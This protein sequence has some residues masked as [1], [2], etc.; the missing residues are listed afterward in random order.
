M[1]EYMNQY[2][3][4]KHFYSTHTPLIME[5]PRNEWAGD[6]YAWDRWIGMT[7][8]E[9]WL[10]GDIRDA[11]AV[12]YPQY[13]VG[14]FFVD[15]ANPRAKVAIECDGK[16]YHR[17]VEK[18]LARQREIEAMGWRVYRISGKQCMTDFN[19]ETLE[20]GYARRFIEEIADAHG[21]RRKNSASVRHFH[22]HQIGFLDRLCKQN[23]IEIEDDSQEQRQEEIAQLRST[24]R[25]L[26][27]LLEDEKSEGGRDVLM[28]KY[29]QTLAKRRN[30]TEIPA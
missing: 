22:N 29:R 5:T 25:H 26:L 30:L 16:A 4:A 12:F 20:H 19:D 24:E 2:E 27:Q 11:N 3:A 15:F 10:W 23:G 1:T 6:P 7:P 18:D 9:A 21:L 8:I 17:D 28:A 14:R 13:P